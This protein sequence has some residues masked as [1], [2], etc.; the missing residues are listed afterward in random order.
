[1]VKL[2]NNI[3]ILYN[4]N[5]NAQA[6]EKVGIHGIWG[7]YGNWEVGTEGCETNRKVS[8]LHIRKRSTRR[9][10]YDIIISANHDGFI[11]N[12]YLQICISVSQ[13]KF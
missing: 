2:Y 12:S 7:T 3:S 10:G 9:T 6:L 5:N 1:M 8:R 11:R 4:I 13:G